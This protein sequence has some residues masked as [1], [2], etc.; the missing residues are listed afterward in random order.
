MKA[1]QKNCFH[2][3]AHLNE[4]PFRYIC[5]LCGRKLKIASGHYPKEKKS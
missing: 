4:L 2:Q 1:N 5:L 3:L